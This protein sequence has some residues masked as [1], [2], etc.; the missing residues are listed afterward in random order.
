[1]R[2]SGSV[3]GGGAGVQALSA[4]PNVCCKM[5]ESSVLFSAAQ[6]CSA[7]VETSIVGES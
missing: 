5:H 7:P 2:N 1:M 6:C 3:S 4:N